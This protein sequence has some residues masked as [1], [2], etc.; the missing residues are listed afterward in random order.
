MGPVCLGGAG[1]LLFL[2]YDINSFTLRSRLLHCAFGAGVAA[3]AGSKT[4]LAEIKARLSMQTICPD[5]INQ[6]RNQQ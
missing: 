3:V 1:F 2:L 5:K 6:L 4:N